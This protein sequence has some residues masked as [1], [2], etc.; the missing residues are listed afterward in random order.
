MRTGVGHG[1]KT[2]LVVVQ[3]EVLIAELVAVDG[4]AASALCRGEE[5]L[6][7]CYH[8]IKIGRPRK[9]MSAYVTAGE[10]ATLQ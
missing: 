9:D 3:G 5:G 2:R 4:F 10:V 8:K 1:E 6:A 7:F